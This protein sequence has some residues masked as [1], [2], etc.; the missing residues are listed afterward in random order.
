MCHCTRSCKFTSGRILSREDDKFR[1]IGYSSAFQGKFSNM[2]VYMK[3][4]KGTGCEGSGMK[5][6]GGGEP[7]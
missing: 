5:G 7:S 1:V 2:V 6:V 3:K 4:D